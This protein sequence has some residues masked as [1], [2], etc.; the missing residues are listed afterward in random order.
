MAED[1]KSPGPVI[2]AEIENQEFEKVEEKV[3]E[4]IKKEEEEVKEMKEHKVGAAEFEV[5]EYDNAVDPVV[6][7]Y[8][9][10]LISTRAMIKSDIEVRMLEI[11]KSVEACNT[12]SKM[13]KII[14]EKLK[15]RP[16]EY[17]IISNAKKL[18]QTYN[19]EKLDNTLLGGTMFK[20]TLVQ[21]KQL[22]KS[23]AK[24]EKKKA[25]IEKKKKKM[26]EEAGFVTAPTISL[27]RAK[28]DQNC[29][30][31]K[32]DNISIAYGKNLLLEN[33][34]L[35]L[36]SGRRYGLIGRNGCGKSTLMRVIATRQV[37]IPDNMTLHFIEQEV[38]GD[39][40]TVYQTVYEA[41]E[42]L[43]KTKADLVELEK[44]PLVNAEKINSTIAKLEDMEADTAE[45]RIKTILGGLQFTPQDLYRPTKEFS[46]G[47]RM[48]I[49][50]AKAIY[51]KPD[52]LLLDEPSNHLDFHA[53]VWLE[54]VLKTWEGTILLVS[55]QR[56]FL[57]AIVTDIIHFK[58]HHLMCYP[59]DYDTFEATMQKRILQQQREYDA[60]QLQK[61]HI[62]QF[63]DRFRY[64]A[65]RGPQVQ[66]RIKMMEKMKEVSTVIDDAEVSLNFPEVEPLDTSIVSF[67]DISFG[68]SPEKILFRDLNFALTMESRV[69]LV[70]RNGCGKTTFLKLLIN[71]LSPVE[72]TVQRNRKARIGVFAQHFVDQLNFKVNAI[73]FF[74][75]KYP[76]K[77][78]QEIRTHLGKFG[79]SGDSSLQRLDTLSGGQKSRVVFADLAYK[80]PHLLLLDEPSNH[81]DIETVEALAR[82]LS[83]FQGGVLIITHDERLISQVCDEIWHLHD[84]TLDKF[85]GD[86]VD[87]KRYVRKEIFK[88]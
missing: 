70:G 27:N 47:W 6:A 16:L 56:Q 34:D 21:E 37:A 7:N 55:H 49:S 30:D 24:L 72:G 50:I 42:E 33:A 58:D 11:M 14:S 4:E 61:K 45:S 78:V 39:D 1:T 46:G 75:N 2:H 9:D 10:S 36:A 65:T 60:Q 29:K 52:L 28:V 66:S 48:R 12:E 31:V 80:Q 59:G 43:V 63:I 35:T 87:Y 38:N 19:V 81:L 23:E 57:N 5:E 8:I 68:Y 84:K 22:E 41:N 62:Q 74:Q 26:Q 82:S 73:Q 51:M 44:E 64:S 83:V 20:K 13:K 76:E 3:E 17:D 79:I 40:R 67:H 71:S 86:I 32:Q 54:E 69:A 77:T 88:N 18:K 53:L 25:E 85:P 15:N